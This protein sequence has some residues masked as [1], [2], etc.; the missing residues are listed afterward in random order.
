MDNYVNIGA[1]VATF[2][3]KGEVVIQ[4]HLGDNPDLVGLKVMFIETLKDKFIPF[5]I[6]EI[7]LKSENELLVSFEDI[8]SPETAKKYL[9]KKAWLTELEA[10]KF[11]SKAAP[12]SLLGFA[13]VEKK[14]ILGKVLEVIEQP[15]QILLR[16]EI[17]SKEVLIPINESTLVKIDHKSEKIFVTLPAG[18]LDIYLT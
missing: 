9:K 18:L 15:L 1:I 7:K 5:F 3:V 12:I 8:E 2:G 4:H 6:K 14:T 17:D 16:I 11:S 10:K 13:V